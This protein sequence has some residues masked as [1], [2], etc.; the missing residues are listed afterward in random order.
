MRTTASSRALLLTALLA[1]CRGGATDRVD[2][3]GTLET[4]E[5]DLGFQTPG[6]IDSLLVHEGDAVVAGQRLAVLD[7]GELVA[8]RAAAA[9]QVAAQRARLSELERGFRPEEIAQGRAALRAAEQRVTDATRDRTRARNLFQGGVIS[10]QALDAAET[11]ATLAEAE[12]DRLRDQVTLLEQGPR[13]E[14]LEAQR[15]QVTQMTAQLAQ[16]DAALGFAVI[17]APFAGTISRRLRE[18]G[19]VVSAG[20]P[21]LTLADP[22]DRW[23][24]IY[25]REDEVGRVAIGQP[26]TIRIDAFPDRTYRG[27][28]SFISNEAE[29]TPRNVQ[30]REE[31]VKLVYRVKVRVVGDTLQDLKPGLSAD[32]RLG[33]ET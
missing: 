11:A 18:P 16:V 15:A 4:T 25:V 32:V 10:Q 27:E 29:F 14:Q 13:V 24:R 26:A 17:T 2:A 19:E 1:A 8:R 28:V 9:A 23:V 7:R 20:L 30:T 3:S 31:R 5:A 12:R 33:A 22:A 6:R 21:V